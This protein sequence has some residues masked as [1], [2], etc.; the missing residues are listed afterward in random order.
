M[1]EAGIDRVAAKVDQDVVNMREEAE[2]DERDHAPHPEEPEEDEANG[3]DTE[4]EVDAPGQ[5]VAG[6]KGFRT[7]VVCSDVLGF[8]HGADV[9]RGG[10]GTMCDENVLAARY[11]YKTR[12]TTAVISP[13]LF[14]VS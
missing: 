7:E 4:A 3:A 1:A 6:N 8:E 11:I 13:A 14:P 5:K 9:R 10:S 2:R 12:C